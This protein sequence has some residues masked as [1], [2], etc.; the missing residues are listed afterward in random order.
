[1]VVIGGFDAGDVDDVL[2]F[3][4]YPWDQ[5]DIQNINQLVISREGEHV[6]IAYHEDTGYQGSVVLLGV[7][8]TFVAAENLWIGPYP[9]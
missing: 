6:R 8:E 9:Y 2:Q 3:D 4:L 5:M 7:A 1:M